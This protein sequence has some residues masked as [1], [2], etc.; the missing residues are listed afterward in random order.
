MG[1]VG[2]SC[3]IL[4]NNIIPYMLIK[5]IMEV[6]DIKNYLNEEITTLPMNDIKIEQI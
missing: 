5:F 6:K 1:I 4:D 2:P 3:C